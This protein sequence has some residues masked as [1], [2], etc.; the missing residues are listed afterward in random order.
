VTTIRKGRIPAT[1]ICRKN[2]L[3]NKLEYKG[4]KVRIVKRKRFKRIFC[5]EKQKKINKNQKWQIIIQI[6]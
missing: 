5:E 2:K 6:D 4:K 3:A 1:T